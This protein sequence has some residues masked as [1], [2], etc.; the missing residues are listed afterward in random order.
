MKIEYG[1]IGKRKETDYRDERRVGD[2]QNILYIHMYM[3]IH[4]KIYLNE[5]SYLV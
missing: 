2:D 1:V 3:Y 5:T 4:M